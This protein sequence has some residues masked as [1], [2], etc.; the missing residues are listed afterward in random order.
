MNILITGIHGFVG[1]NLV[2]ALKQHHTIYGLDIVS[3]QKDGV[4]KTYGWNELHDIPPIDCMIHLA[5]KAHDTKKQANAQVYFDINTGLTQKIFDWFLTTNASKFIYFSSAKA[6]ADQ[7]DGEILTE[8]V[9]PKP[10]GPYGESKIA[11]EEYILSSQSQ[12]K[13][14]EKRIQGAGSREQGAWEQSSNKK[15]FI[16]RPCMIH[17]PGNKGNLNLLYKLVQK[18]IPWPLGAFENKRSFTSIDNLTFVINQI[19]EKD[20]EPGIYNMAD[21]TPISTNHL[22]EIIAASKGKKVRI[23]RINQ[24][25]ISI[26]ARI[27]DIFHLPLNSERLKKLTESYVVS[28]QKLKKAL[29]IEKMP[30]SAEEGMKK[31]LESFRR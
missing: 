6:A 30:V 5:G 1:S 23:W 28:N 10:K 13:V 12:N 7:V 16:L 20:I 2:A 24:K 26:A 19:I 29:G 8:D 27:G 18:G 31:T 9:I 15:V 25:L 14:Q 4:T 3:P 22:I 17:G 21:D 11:A